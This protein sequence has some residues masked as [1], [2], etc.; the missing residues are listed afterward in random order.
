MLPLRPGQVEHH[1]HDYRRTGTLVLS[2]A[3]EIATGAV[4]TQ[5][6][7]RHRV[8]EFLDFL[9]PAR[10]DVPAAAAPPRPRQLEDPQDARGSKV[11]GAPQAGSPSLHPDVRVAAEPG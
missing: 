5:T 4:K 2:A 3:L 11:A 6:S 10:A 1:T 8:T 7:A 9:N